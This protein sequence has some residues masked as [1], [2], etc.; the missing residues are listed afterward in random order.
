MKK[1]RVLNLRNFKFLELVNKNRVLLLISISFLIGIITATILYSKNSVV[2]EY[3]NNQ[4]NRY[5]G[6]RS[7]SNLIGIAFKSFLASMLY[8][9][10][11][12]IFGTS[13]LGTIL[14]P[15]TVFLRG[16]SGGALSALLYNQYSLK[17]IALNAVLIIP[18]TII[19]VIAFIY[20]ANKAF[21]FSLTVASLTLPHSS[22]STL[23]LPFKKYCTDFLILLFAVLVSALFDAVL[24]DFLFPIFEI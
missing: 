7:N 2:V 13:M 10:A 14:V 11:V 24:S 22:P 23:F 21:N 9:I 6:V 18:P 17:G 12:Y 5:L 4:L 20:G 3:A 1:S 8:L 16:F 15:I 19:F